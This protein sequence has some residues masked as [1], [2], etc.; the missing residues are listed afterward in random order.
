MAP[1]CDHD[2]MTLIKKKNFLSFLYPCNEVKVTKEIIFIGHMGI[3]RFIIMTKT[4]LFRE[5]MVTVLLIA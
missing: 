1:Y 3:F 5:V 4:L 2:K